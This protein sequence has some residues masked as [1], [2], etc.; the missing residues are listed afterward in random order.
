M[1]Q[2]PPIDD[3]EILDRLPPEYQDLLARANGYVAYNGGLHVRGACREP[4][5]HSLRAAWEGPRALALL[6]REVTPDDVPFAEDALGDQFLL[7]GGTV[8]RLDAEMGEMRSL[9]LDLADFDAAVRAD[10][11]GYLSLAPL[12]NFR[13]RG[14]ELKPGQLLS[15]YPPFC[16]ATPAADVSLRAVPAGDRIAF[17]AG[18]AAQIHELPDGT[19][20]RIHLRR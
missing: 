7:R 13:A 10:P 15:A 1:Y 20:V 3:F 8:H 4:E 11:V 19:P 5:W 16:L 9:G 18:F 6:F 2:G 14:G 12:Q 17:L